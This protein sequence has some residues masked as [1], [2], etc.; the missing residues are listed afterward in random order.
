MRSA[1]CG[2]HLARCDPGC[3]QRATAGFTL[4]EL[5][6]AITLTGLVLVLLYSALHLASRSWDAAERRA[7]ETAQVRVV[8]DFLR[9]KLR[10]ARSLA[11]HE[12]GRPEDAAVMRGSLH[13]IEFVAPPPAFLGP[14]GLHILALS[15]EPS[16]E[17]EGDDLVLQWRPYRSEVSRDGFGEE[18]R[19]VAARGLESLR[20][21][22][23]G[24]ERAGG[25]PNWH[26]RWEDE[27]RL[28]LLVAVEIAQD[29]K[30]WPEL[31]VDM[32]Q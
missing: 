5:L 11:W 31:V 14:K 12:E 7:D 3:A 2:A 23:F 20:F 29:E 9:R 4:I 15:L 27:L 17:A 19:A 28:P 6:I 32:H 21:R 18:D 10:Q 8:H 25:E 26:E 22:Y 24:A 30:E 16:R 1:G 13:D